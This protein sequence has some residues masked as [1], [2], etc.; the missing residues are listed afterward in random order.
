MPLPG[1]ILGSGAALVGGGVVSGAAGVK[2]MSD[3]N[4][5]IKQADMEYRENKEKLEKEEEYTTR[6]LDALGRF[7]LDIWESFKRFSDAF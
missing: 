4:K 6:A 3:A 7:K 1:I 2:K 5:I